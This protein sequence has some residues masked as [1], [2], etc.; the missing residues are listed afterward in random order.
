MFTIKVSTED[1]SLFEYLNIEATMVPDNKFIFSTKER[2]VSVFGRY[3]YHSLKKELVEKVIPDEAVRVELLEDFIKFLP[4]GYEEP[5]KEKVTEVLNDY[6]PEKETIHF[7]VEGFVTFR[8][9]A[10]KNSYADYLKEEFEYFCE[11]DPST[12]SIESIIEMMDSSPAKAK[13]L[14]IRTLEDGKILLS[15]NEECFY[16][17]EEN[18]QENIVVQSV[19][20]APES[21][22]IL[23]EYDILKRESILV[24]QKLFGENIHFGGQ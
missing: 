2:A 22:T 24:L 18:E 20:L 10:I 19:F 17:E 14:T 12:E 3:I 11:T 15:E 7:F 1:D 13:N 16:I 21:V 9:V 6:F 23:D 4:R 8:M 5:W